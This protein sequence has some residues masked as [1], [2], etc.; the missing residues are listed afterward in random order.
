MI[1]ELF[2]F[3]GRRRRAR[4][5]IYALLTYVVLFL[6]LGL[7]FILNRFLGDSSTLANL[8]L[9]LL[10]IPLLW[11]SVAQR[12]KRIHDIG[13]PGWLIL[14]C[15]MPYIN[16]FFELYLFLCPGTKGKNDYGENPRLKNEIKPN[17]II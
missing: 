16:I 12:V 4:Y 7:F 11:F 17:E 3:K 10:F 6:G 2:S 14:I 9:C 8:L 13:E 5:V 15:M 1:N